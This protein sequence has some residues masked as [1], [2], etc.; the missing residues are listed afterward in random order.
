MNKRTEM[1]LADIKNLY[2]QAEERRAHKEKQG[3]FFNVFNTIG[4]RTE[5]VR[6]HSA[7]IAELLNPNG[8]HGLSNSF[9]EIFLK[10][11]WLPRNYVKGAKE[12]VKERPIGRKTKTEGGRID[13]IIEDGNRAIIIENKIYAE[14]QENQLLRY[15]NYGKKHFG[16]DFILIYLT[17]DGDE[18][19]ESSL[20]E[21]NIPFKLLS[22]K[23]DIIEWL[24]D[25]V[26][27]AR[28][29]PLAQAIIIQYRELLKQLTNTDMDTKYKEDLMSLIL[30]PENINAV[31]EILKLQGEWESEI[32]DKYI[33]KPLEEYAHSKG[34]E[35]GM[36]VQT[37]ETGAW[38]YNKSWKHYGLHI[39]TDRIHDWNDMYI[40]IS[41]YVEPDR[42]NKIH[43]K[44]YH[45]LDCLREAPCDNWPYGWE[46]LPDNIRNWGFHITEEIVD[47][48]VFKFIKDKFEEILIELEEKKWLKIWEE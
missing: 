37:G 33:W 18:P 34:M 3:E 15:Y 23:H 9:L 38:I 6:L 47:G 32:I 7:M 41:W 1:L 39:W 44:D 29:K 46:Y 30:K 31:G 17:L 36:R 8:M 21:R 14:D 35:F 26:E 22:Y 25:C 45:P 43:K 12:K 42:K 10:R 2:K 20:G 4:L 28:E 40:G 19:N 11:L 13:I 48:K 24:G 16:D 27:I 5:E